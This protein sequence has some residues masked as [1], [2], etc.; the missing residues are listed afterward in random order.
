MEY[1]I[2]NLINEDTLKKSIANNDDDYG[3]AIVQVAI[4]VME[5]LDSFEGDFNIGYSP[6]M[7]T[8]HGIICHCDTEGGI[9]GFMAGAARNITANCHILGWKFYLADVISPFSLE[10]EEMHEKL[11]KNLTD[12]GLASKDEVKECIK[13]LIERYRAANPEK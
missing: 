13:G 7:T 6:D 8:P 9:T 1:N 2:K 10:D 3:K 11:A 5:H 12:A 4:N